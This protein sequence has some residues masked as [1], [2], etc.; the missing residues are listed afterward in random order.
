[1]L[2]QQ[3]SARNNLK[4]SSD[5]RNI[6]TDRRVIRGNTY[7]ALVAPQQQEP[8]QSHKAAQRTR[9]LR[10]KHSGTAPP[11]TPPPVYR[12]H[13]IDIQTDTYLEELTERT[14]EFE[15]E[16]QTEFLLD[17][18]ASPLFV[19]AKIGVDMETQIED[20]ELFDFDFEVQPILEVL[21]GKTLEQ[22]L[23]EVL[24]EEEISAM[25]QRQ[26]DFERCRMDELMEVQRTEAVEKR[27]S[28]E[29]AR[30]LAQAEARRQEQE[31]VCKKLWAREFACSCLRG[32]QDNAMQQVK[33]EGVFRDSLETSVQ[34]EFTPW[35]VQTVVDNVTSDMTVASEVLNSKW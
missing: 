29:T 23:M 15:A 24:E 33:A 3:R 34:S 21:V 30:R 12:R 11:R 7:A 6:M 18:P 19:P 28:E 20:G 16:T 4:G 8:S 17:L 10:A 1:M 14:M 27:R 32:V 31:S 9:L 35:L 13:H 2:H 5:T 22:S 25:R 26:E